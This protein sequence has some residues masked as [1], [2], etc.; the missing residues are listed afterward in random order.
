M[1]RIGRNVTRF[2]SDLLYVPVGEGPMALAP[3]I[4]SVVDIVQQGWARREM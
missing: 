2:L 4:S 1:F 3:E